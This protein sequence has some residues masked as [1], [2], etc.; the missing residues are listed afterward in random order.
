M[1]FS[2]YIHFFLNTEIITFI[3]ENF[4][5][6]EANIK[7]KLKVN[8]SS[9]YS[10]YVPVTFYIFKMHA[11]YKNEIILLHISIVLPIH[12]WDPILFTFSINIYQTSMF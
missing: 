9:E 12:E 5:K 4:L 2:L 11:V 7:K 1:D 10:G 3:R 8:L 6:S